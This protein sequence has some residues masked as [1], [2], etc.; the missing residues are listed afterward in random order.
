MML[1][2][3]MPAAISPPNDR[4]P[5][6]CAVLARDASADGRFFYSVRTTGVY[7]RPSCASR[8][9][10]PRNVRFHAT[11]AAA[12]AAGFRPC[13]RCKPDETPLAA[14]RSALIARACRSI[15]REIAA[16]DSPPTLMELA[17]AAKLS[18]YHF[19]RLFK[20]EAGVMPR[21]YAAAKR[22]ERLRSDLS[23]APSVTSA[24]YDAGFNA[25]SRFY[26]QADSLIGM[27]PRAYRQ[28]GKDVEFRFALGRCSFGALLVAMSAKGVCAILL[29]DKPAALD[30]DLR[31]RFPRARLVAGDQSFMRVVAKVVAFVEASARQFAL[32]LD[33]RG[34]AF[35]QRVWRALQ[36]I[37]PGETASY[38]EIAKRIG[39]S[40]AARAVGGACGANAVAVAIPCHRAV[41]SDGSL[42]GYRWGVARKRALLEKEGRKRARPKKEAR[43]T[44]GE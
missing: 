16:G 15:E 26:Q 2:D 34:T 5:R 44:R 42:A 37:P 32:P 43:Q 23:G 10:N 18:R 25:S 38:A 9:A 35:Q 29:G 11:A 31:T 4:D 39:Q 19:H 24:I 6:W 20:A 17:V 7:C 21:D 8:A 36:D 41:T 27:T 30:R 1:A 33:V 3:A 22:A 12:E 40:K 13:K 28:G 14:K